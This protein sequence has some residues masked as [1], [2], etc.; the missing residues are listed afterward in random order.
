MEKWRI[1]IAEPKDIT[2]KKQVTERCLEIANKAKFPTDYE[3]MY[4]HLF[5][6]EEAELFMIMDENNKIYGFATCDNIIESST[7]YIQGIIIHP[8]IQGMGFSLKLLHEI[9][10]KDGNE[11]L[12]LR[13]HNP[14]I[15][16][17]M[18]RMAYKDNLIFPQIVSNKI[19]NQ[20]WKVVASHPAMRD[21]DK[22]LI[23]RNAYPDEKLMQKVKNEEIKT[24]F[25]KLNM[26]D[27][28]VIVVCTKE[29]SFDYD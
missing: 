8:D 13:S 17:I 22:N 4:E 18:S 7:T 16:E 14:R 19:P 26:T 5:G 25:R 10:K 29:P 1:S 24:L 23:V 21:A 6:N 27:A 20:I 15:Y 28:Q 3:D 12:T 11:F 2:S 9:I